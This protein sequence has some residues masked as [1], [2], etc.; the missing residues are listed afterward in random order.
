M[1]AKEY[2]KMLDP[3]VYDPFLFRDMIFPMPVPPPMEEQ[4]LNDIMLH[5]VGTEPGKLVLKKNVLLY[6]LQVKIHLFG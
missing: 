5:V 6:L 1:T 2:A 3:I 4:H